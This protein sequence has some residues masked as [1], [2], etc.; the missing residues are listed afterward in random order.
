MHNKCNELES[1]RNHPCPLSVE[2]LSFRKPVPGAKKVGDH[3]LRGSGLWLSDMREGLKKQ[4]VH[5]RLDAVRK[6]GQFYN[7]VSRNLTYGQG[8]LV[9]KEQPVIV[10]KRRGVWYFM[11]GT[12]TSVL[13]VLRQD[14]EVGLF[15]LT[16]SWS[17]SNLV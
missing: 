8:K 11:G 13:S 7:R 14:Y 4:G 1:S 2:K 17:Q 6:Q 5:S 16:L 3:C 10:A 15:C 9:K 12:V